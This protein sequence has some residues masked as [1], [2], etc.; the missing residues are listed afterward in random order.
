MVYGASAW[1]ITGN[2][3]RGRCRRLSFSQIWSD[4]GK[5]TESAQCSMV[6][7]YDA[8]ADMGQL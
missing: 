7:A 8:C 4:V 3:V 6:K 5:S 1:F 2:A